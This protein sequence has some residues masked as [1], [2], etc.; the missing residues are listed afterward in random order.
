MTD[1]QAADLEYIHLMEDTFSV[2]LPQGH[3][4]AQCAALSLDQLRQ[5]RFIFLEPEDNQAVE[6]W[7]AHNG[8]LPHIQYRVKDDYTIMA[9]V[10]NGL[11]I[12]IL[13][14]LVLSR[15]PY[16]VHAVGLQ[17][18]CTRQ[19]GIIL[20]KNGSVSLATRYLI[21]FWK[22]ERERDAAH[23]V[24]SAGAETDLRQGS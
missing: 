14:N 10:E 5:E 20:P 1:P 13:P 21:S 3:P 15:M 19:I 4:L 8:F 6:D 12:S 2:I 7:M 22:Q 24:S 11:G 16:R 23:A 9:L 17:P 18:P